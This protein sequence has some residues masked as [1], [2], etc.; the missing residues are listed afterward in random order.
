M[1]RLY[2]DLLGV[3][4]GIH[5]QAEL[6]L[7]QPQHDE[8]KAV[9]QGAAS[10]HWPLA[11]VGG[12]VV[13][14]AA[15]AVRPLFAAVLGAFAGLRVGE[16]HRQVQHL[17]QAEHRQQ[18]PAQPVHLLVVHHLQV[19]VHR[20][21]VQPD[22]FVDVDLRDGEAGPLHRDDERRHDGQGQRQLYGH[23]GARA[24]GGEDVHRAAEPAEGV[25]DHVHAHAAAGQVG[26]L[27][28]QGEAGQEHQVI[29]LPGGHHLGLV[30][31]NLSAPLRR[32]DNLIG[33]HA[34]AVVLDL[35]V[36]LTVA[37]EGEQAHHPS[38]RLAHRLTLGWRLD[39]V[40]DGVAHQ[41]VE[42]IAQ[43]VD[44]VLVQL[45]IRAQDLQIHLLLHLPRQVPRDAVEAGEHAPD[46]AHAGL[47]D[48]GLQVRRHHAE[49]LGSVHQLL[50]ICRCHGL[51]VLV[52]HQHQLACQVHQPIKQGHRDAY[53]GV[54]AAWLGAGRR[55]R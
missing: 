13:A 39:A 51:H 26:D 54:G 32:R 12:H 40:A 18:P 14:L 22:H 38:P 37:V 21:A 28:G 1:Q 5:Q 31:G 35:D 20:L 29:R 52:A 27:F 41:V 16:G 19:L 11:Q 10:L 42:G 8:V 34:L 55:G 48:A 43:G 45:H 33:I 24:A 47:H 49:P 44:D 6:L 25:L 23:P 30:G 36:D 50:V 46:G 7:P 3:H 4:D 9:L 2:H 53:V 17:G 15:A